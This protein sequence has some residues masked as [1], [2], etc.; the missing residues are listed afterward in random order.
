MAIEIVDCFGGIGR[1]GSLLR[2]LCG[3][4]DEWVNVLNRIGEGACKV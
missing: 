1:G 2:V 3:Y 4:E